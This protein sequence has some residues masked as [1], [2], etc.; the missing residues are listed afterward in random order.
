MIVGAVL[1]ELGHTHVVAVDGRKAISALGKDTFDLVLMDIRMP[2]MDGLTALAEIRRSG[3]A[4]ANIPI[5]A[6]TADITSDHIAAYER[7]GFNAIAKKPI[8]VRELTTAMNKAL[9]EA[10]HD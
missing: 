1:S 8:D 10:V 7:K 4:Y 9:G 5:V 3:A 6:L 2:E